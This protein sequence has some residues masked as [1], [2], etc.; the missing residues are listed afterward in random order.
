MSDVFISHVEEDAAIA[1]EIARGLN[2]AGY[3]TWCYEEDNELG[4]SYL[5]QIGE[6]IEACQAVVLVI[7]PESLGSDQVTREVEYSHEARKRFVPV[8][9]GISHVEFQNRRASWRVALGTASSIPVPPDGVSAILPRI[10]RGLQGLGVKPTEREC[11]EA[12]RLAKEKAEA[13]R[14]LRD[15]AEQ[16]RLARA[17]VETEHRA[18][19]QADAQRKAHEKGAQ[20]E[21]DRERAEAERRARKNPRDGLKYVWIPPG[22]FMMGCSPGDTWGSEEEKPSHEVKI[23]KGFWLGQTQ[24]TVAAFKRFAQETSAE[25]PPPPDFNPSWK[26]EQMPI[27]NVTW[28]DA[29]AY[30]AWAGGRLPTEAEWVYAARGGTTG[31][32]YGPL[33]EIAWSSRNSHGTHD[34]GQ[35]R[36]QQF[37]PVRHA[38]ERLGMGQ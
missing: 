23:G 34:V 30:C 28:R 22:A 14:E 29:Q 7:S 21:R 36:P 32:W 16:D 15:K 2:V 9:K 1:L 3:T 37:W 19:E 13:E 24:V 5:K 38:G 18:R 26:N 25:L 8:L 31:V 6:A 10:V 20:E 35:K 11:A 27:V 17:R 4:A 33:D 12:G